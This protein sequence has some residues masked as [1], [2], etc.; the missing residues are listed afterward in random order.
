MG[1][2]LL[3]LGKMLFC[4]TLLVCLIAGAHC[5]LSNHGPTV[6]SPHIQHRFNKGQARWGNVTNTESINDFPLQISD[7]EV[8]Y[9]LLVQGSSTKE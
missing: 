3:I 2:M 4:D 5:E 1:K 9:L 6:P 7:K 8:L